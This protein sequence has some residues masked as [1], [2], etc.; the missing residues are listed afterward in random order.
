MFL[1][2][3]IAALE[4]R[5]KPIPPKLEQAAWDDQIAL[6]RSGG[7][8]QARLVGGDRELGEQIATFMADRMASC[9]RNPRNGG[10]GFFR[11]RDIPQRNPDYE[12]VEEHFGLPDD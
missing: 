11:D 6:D 10:G 4:A 8:L 2:A 9:G 12:T 7:R 5:G 1:R 3:R